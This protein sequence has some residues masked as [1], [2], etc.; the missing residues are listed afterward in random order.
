MVVDCVEFHPTHPD[1]LMVSA[2]ECF[3][4]YEWTKGR[5]LKTIEKE[6]R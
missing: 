4:V 2:V 1:L 5:C 3:S 6:V